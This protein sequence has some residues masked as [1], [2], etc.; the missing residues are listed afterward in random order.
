MVA[1]SRAEE[2]EEAAYQQEETPTSLD[3]CGMLAEAE[4]K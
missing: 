3:R 4:S 1:N 2:S